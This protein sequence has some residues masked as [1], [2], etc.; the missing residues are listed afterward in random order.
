M[1]ALP[2]SVIRTAGGS[3]SDHP[4]AILSVAEG[5]LGTLWKSGGLIVPPV[6]CLSAC[7]TASHFEWLSED[8]FQLFLS[9]ALPL[10]ISHAYAVFI[11]SHVRCSWLLIRITNL[12]A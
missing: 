6:S 4:C 1:S 9:S 8:P 3:S 2:P 11:P 7:A 12:I 5:R 10:T